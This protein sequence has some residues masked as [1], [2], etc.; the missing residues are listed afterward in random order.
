MSHVGILY[1]GDDGDPPQ[2][3]WDSAE[4]VVYFGDPDLRMY[5]P[6]TDYSDANHWDRPQSLRY[7]ADLDI[8]GHMPFGSTEYPHKIES[9]LPLDQII[10]ILIIC[11]VLVL[12]V[13]GIILVKRKK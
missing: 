4:N 9:T 2:W 6:G 8:N 3:W 12:V 11:I 7:E 1:L 10:L 13:V 5:V